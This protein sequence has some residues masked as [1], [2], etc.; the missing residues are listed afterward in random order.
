MRTLLL[1][2]ASVTFSS[3]IYAQGGMGKL[4]REDVVMLSQVVRDSLSDEMFARIVDLRRFALANN[5]DSAAPLIAF[6][7]GGGKIWAWS[8]ACDLKNP[9]DVKR[10]NDVLA[11]L[12]KMFT[13]YP[14]PMHQEYFAVFK[15]KD[16]PSGQLA[17]YQINLMK[18]NKKKMTS[19][20]YY[21]VGDKLLFGDAN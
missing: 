21:P 1:F 3:S 4:P 11:K 9:D 16:A 5:A 7:T 8:R 13:D 19:F 12:K 2:I 18:G 20:H 17:H 15:T 14:D 10:V 6:N